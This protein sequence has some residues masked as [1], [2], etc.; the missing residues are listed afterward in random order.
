MK[1]KTKSKKAKPLS[2][3]DK[4]S[5]A[6]IVGIRREIYST[7]NSILSL[8]SRVDKVDTTIARE[9]AALRESFQ[10][11]DEWRDRALRAEHALSLTAAPVEA[12]WDGDL[13]KL[14]DEQL[15]KFQKAIDNMCRPG[16]VKYWQDRFD[17]AQANEDAAKKLVDTWSAR[18]I[19]AEGSMKYAN[20]ALD[21][22]KREDEARWQTIR[23]I[24]RPL[25]FEMF[26]PMDAVR[27]MAKLTFAL[28]EE[29]NKDQAEK[30]AYIK[31]RL[32][33][34]VEQMPD[35]D[36]LCIRWTVS[37]TPLTESSPPDIVL[38]GTWSRGTAVANRNC[39][40][41]G[42]SGY[43][44]KDSPS[45]PDA[46]QSRENAAVEEMAGH[47]I[48]EYAKGK[49]VPEK[50]MDY[51]NR[52]GVGIRNREVGW[53]TLTDGTIMRDFPETRPFSFSPF[54]LQR[55]AFSSPHSEVGTMP[56]EE[57]K[58]KPLRLLVEVVAQKD[59][60]HG[61]C[62]QIFENGI[63]LETSNTEYSNDL[64]MRPAMSIEKLPDMPSVTYLAGVLVEAFYLHG[65]KNY[66][67]VIKDVLAACGLEVTE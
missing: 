67:V 30:D 5:M 10:L 60:K 16:S 13:T 1:P 49:F 65:E 8:R 18:A 48:P 38:Y 35:P 29:L 20:D 36:C 50:V 6:D 37:E 7:G 45:P 55:K 61:T 41:C 11:T 39:W 52:M 43:R 59:E 53:I 31:S 44:R 51:M 9:I 4:P 22:F 21:K 26:A 12:T 62:S 66:Q 33:E 34:R 64:D 32:D 14:N 63:K 3:L 56:R 19:S 54:D 25:G 2:R 17:K 27:E 40:N 23:E 24:V 28:R 15:E 42:G 58:E 46:E 47:R 57:A